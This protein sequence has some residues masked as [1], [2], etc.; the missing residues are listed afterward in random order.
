[1]F[2]SISKENLAMDR[3]TQRNGTSQ[4]GRD[5]G[6]DIYTRL[7]DIGCDTSRAK[8]S[9][10]IACWNLAICPRRDSNRGRIHLEPVTWRNNK[11]PDFL[12]E[13]VEALRLC[14]QTALL[15]STEDGAEFRPLQTR[16][17]SNSCHEQL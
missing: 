3:Q 16:N 5:D 14:A 6:S 2:A 8:A 17:H 11:V 4:S 13:T 15:Y 12:V 7:R 10:P 1:M 9:L